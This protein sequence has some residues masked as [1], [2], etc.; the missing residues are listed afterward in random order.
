MDST[1]QENMLWTSDEEEWETKLD[2]QF[3]CQPHHGLQGE[4][5]RPTTLKS[6][7]HL[8]QNTEFTQLMC[9]FVLLYKSAEKIVVTGMITCPR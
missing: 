8:Q 5:A 3:L 7:V 6:H 9:T 4:P 2:D 1:S